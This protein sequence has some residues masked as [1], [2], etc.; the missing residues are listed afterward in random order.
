MGS[1]K[2]LFCSY[3]LFS[4]FFFLIGSFVKTL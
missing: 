3:H 4:S 1:F 2:F